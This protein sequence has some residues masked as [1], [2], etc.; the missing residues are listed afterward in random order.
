[1]SAKGVCFACL[2]RTGLD[3]TRESAASEGTTLFDDFEIA[4]RE[5]GSL[6]ELG[7]GGMGVTYRATD[8]TLHRSVALK[9][10]DPRG[11]EVVRERFLR[12]ARA[13]AALRHPNVAGVFRF[14]AL[15]SG[16]RCYCAMELVEGETLEALVRRNG[17]VKLETALGIAVQATRALTAAADRG[18][19]HRDLKP[20]N[21]MLTH[22]ES[23]VRTIEV[24]V[25]DFGLAKAA[26]VGTGEMELTRGEFVGTPAFASPEQFAGGSIDARTDIYALGVTLWFALTGRLPFAGRTV[27]EIR[28]NQSEQKL[29]LEQLPG[30]PRRVLELLR[31]CLAVDPAE[32]PPSARQ[33]LEALESCRARITTGRRNRKLAVAGIALFALGLAALMFWR[34]PQPNSA[35]SRPL[36]EKSIAVLPFENLSEDKANAYFADG[37]QDEILTRL[38]AIRDLKVISRTSTAKYKSRLENIRKVAEELGV[39]T[40]LEGSVQKAG[41][42]VRINVQL[43][44]ARADTHL[45]AK[46]YDRELKD[47]FAVESEVA[48]EIAET[49]RVKLSPVQSAA[50]ASVPTNDTEAYD[51]FL[52]GEYE[53]H[54]AGISVDAAAAADRADAFYR[55][56]LAR[57]P[58]FVAPAVQLA[59]SRLYRHWYTS[60]LP[61]GELEEVK[62]I[63]DRS[64]ALAPNSPEAHLALGLFFYWGHRQYEMAL[65]EFKRTLELQPN[66]VDALAYCAWIHRRRGEWEPSLAHSQRAQEL[67][68]RDASLP[69]NIGSTYLA[70]RLWKE[71]QQAELRALALDPQNA[72]AAVVLVH[73]RLCETGEASAARQVLSDFPEA[74]NSLTTALSGRRGVSSGGE[75]AAITGVWVYLEVMERRFSDA[76]QT[77]EKAAGHDP[78]GHLQLLAGRVVLRVLAGEGEAA[79]AMGEEAR[80]LLEAKLSESPEDTFALTELSWVYLALGRGADALRASKQ[81]A[82]LVPV[83]KDALDGPIFQ[84][85]LA[86][87]E[88]RAGAPEQAIK[89]LRHLLSIPSGHRL[90]LARLKNDPVWDPIRDRP[91]FQELLSGPEQIGPVT[92]STSRPVGKDEAVAGPPQKSIAVLPFENLSRDP[93]NAYFAEGIQDEILTRLSKIA[94]LKVISRTSTRQYKSASANVRDIGKQLGVAH[95]LEGSVQK[96]GD[97]VRVNVQLINAASDSHLWAETFDRK[98]TDIFAV[99][100]EIAKAIADRL[101]AKLTGEEERV[102]AAKP[103]ENTEAYD[104]YLRGLAYSLKT[105]NTTANA[106]GAQKHLREA[107]RL[108]RKFALGWALLSF[109][110]ARGY[111]TAFLQRTPALREEAR[112]AAETAL[113]LQPN[114]GEAI[115]AKGFYHY[116]C[117]SDYDTAVRYFDQARPLLPNSS[118][119]PELLAYVTRRQGQWDR[120]ESYFTEAE[121]LDPRNVSLLTQHAL[122]YKNRRLFPEALRKLEQILNITPDDVDTIIEKAAIAQAEGDLPRAATLLAPLSLQANNPNALET[123][124]FQAILERRPAPILGRLKDIL[125]K[126]DPALGYTN[127]ELR[128][129]LGW[130]Q[131]VSGDRSAARESWDEARRELESFLKEHSEDP[132]LLGLLAL[133]NAGL[134]DKAAANSRTEQAMAALPM[135]KD[136]VSGPRPTEILARVAA[137]LGEPDRAIPALQK[138]MKTAYSGALG[139]GAPLTPA[140]LRLDPMFDPLRGD[141]RFQELCR[142][143]QP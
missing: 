94:D 82:D 123:Q 104:A 101:Q 139:P 107:V 83:E 99:E 119:I 1:M 77:F 124:V 143:K 76:F 13:A 64:L 49:L 91:D 53:F 54:Q 113:E 66:N 112:E 92:A 132:I 8:R 105:A 7:R 110:D 59:R 121:R 129:W 88:A 58:N 12:E 108:D 106:L 97:A 85:G 86:Q 96:S 26:T 5:D 24:K 60:P 33:L 15:A 38:A 63:I 51:L 10:I 9:V 72:V 11:S 103:T 131:Q 32:R 34:N 17:P 20:G 4:R 127:G 81:A 74:R 27:E 18:L 39:S 52:R 14:G 61:S 57:D 142:D 41:D 23:S 122:S 22:S 89:R 44:D 35:V 75:V 47:V 16:E 114:L 40:I 2:L 116:A 50:M 80:P 45:W 135:E 87:I 118:R 21:I 6:W 29:P 48:Q 141:P 134:E 93:D 117:L 25:I 125:A 84:Q 138:L 128:F 100:S 79:K 102:I 98:L 95:I 3:E 137:Q 109:V 55:R 56:A 42:K 120:S 70:L 62:A 36:A 30:V 130:A 19:V 67:A 31:S 71:A 69:Q 115:L 65:A 78:R 28:Q 126:P 136:A 111:R 43:I 46:S 90:S 73:A 37:V 68:P 140:L 133:T